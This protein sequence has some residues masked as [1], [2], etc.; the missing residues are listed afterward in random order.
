MNA[1]QAQAL[2]VAIQTLVTSIATIVPLV[3]PRPP[4]GRVPIHD[5]YDSPDAFDLS[6]R[7]GADASN[8]NSQ[9]LKNLWDGTPKTFPAFFIQLKIL[10][11]LENGILQGSKKSCK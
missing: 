2:T 3:A 10:V 1:A 5:L 4:I 6:T 7:A 8:E 9:L 11:T